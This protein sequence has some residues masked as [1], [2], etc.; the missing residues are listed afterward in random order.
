MASGTGKEGLGEE[1]KAV[2]GEGGG[3]ERTGE[4]GEKDNIGWLIKLRQA[5]SQKLLNISSSSQ[6]NLGNMT[7][8][9]LGAGTGALVVSHQPSADAPQACAPSLLLHWERMRSRLTGTKR[10]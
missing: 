4:R 2:G 3:E 8:V 1:R 10:R 6:T 5:I 7:V 9:E